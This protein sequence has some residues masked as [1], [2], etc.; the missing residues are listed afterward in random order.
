MVIVAGV[1]PALAALSTPCLC[2]LGY[3]TMRN[4]MAT[5]AGIEPGIVRLKGGCPIRLDDR[6]I[7]GN[8]RNAEGMLPIPHKGGTI[9]LAQSPGALVRFTF[10]KLVPAARFALALFGF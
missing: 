7:G 5:L 1:E 3:T 6:V 2:R 9:S 4:K 8:W 10:L